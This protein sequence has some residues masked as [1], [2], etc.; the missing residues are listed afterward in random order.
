MKNTH[1]FAL[2][3]ISFLTVTFSSCELEEE[4]SPNRPPVIAK[5]TFAVSEKVVYT[6]VIDTI[7]ATDA[8]SEDLFFSISVNDENLFEISQDGQLRLAKDKTLSYDS[9]KQHII[10]VDVTDGESSAS[11]QITINVREAEVANR[12]PEIENQEFTPFEGISPADLIGSIKAEDFNDDPLRFTL[13]SESTLFRVSLEGEIRLNEGATLDYEE[14]KE[15]L[16]EVEV[17]D[18]EERATATMSIKVR[19]VD[20]VPEVKVLPISVPEDIPDDETIGE[21]HATDFEDDPLEF[22]I[23]IN[24]N[25]L[26]EI[27]ELGQLSLAE[28]RTL[29]FETKS[30]HV[31]TVLVSDGVNEVKTEIGIRVED[32]LEEIENNPDAFITVRKTTLD[33]EEIVIGTFGGVFNYTIDW[34]DGTVE[35]LSEGSPAHVYKKPG[36]YTI[37]ILG[38]FPSINM[39]FSDS[40]LNLRVLKQWGSIHWK[41]LDTAF[42]D[43]INLVYEATDVPDLSAVTSLEGMFGGTTNFD[44]DLSGWDVSNVTNMQSMFVT[45]LSFSGKGLETWNVESL[46]NAYAM[47]HIAESFNGE[48]DNWDVRNLSDVIYMFSQAYA[49][50]RDLGSWELNKVKDMTYM[51]ENATSFEGSGLKN[52]DVSGVTNM[53]RM[54]GHAL[55]FSENISGWNVG[56]VTTMQ[57]M[58]QGTQSFDYSLENWDIGQI[59]NM[60][61]MLSYSQ[62]SSANYNST[63]IGWSQQ[64]NIPQE[65]TLGAHGLTFCEDGITARE[66][67]ISELNWTIQNDFECE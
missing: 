47:F 9:K 14:I 5:Q 31:I 13:L 11:A 51:F 21:V 10:T 53:E 52:W 67:L 61:D 18:G 37:S 1:L 25:N 24:D 56:N 12:A 65:I 49:F 41:F 8:D 44:G 45:A 40:T 15:H 59:Q 27:D 35:Q 63:L 43:C 42:Y 17:F 66:F 36:L 16:I 34:G 60:S 26:F 19:D 22:S 57:G 55:S 23:A 33:N 39:T 54:F 6:Q 7:K 46:T 48:I 62:M 30:T 38:S 3:V 4:S 58:F 50:N 28:N 32:V 29:D 64:Q 2:L 20:F